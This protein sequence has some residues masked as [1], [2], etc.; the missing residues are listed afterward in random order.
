MN[1]VRESSAGQ[2]HWLLRSMLAPCLIGA[3]LL[4]FCSPS[5]TAG[6]DEHP[7]AMEE[8]VPVL[9]YYYIWFTPT[10]WNRAKTDFPL[11]GRYSSDE[12]EVMRQHVQ[13]AKSAGIDGFIVSWKN[14]ATLNQRLEK[15]I[16]V[17]SEEDFKLA[18]I[19]EGLDFEREPLT[20][21][22]VAGDIDLFRQ[23][24]AAEAVFDVYAKPVVI[25]SGTWR[26]T[27]EEVATVTEGRREDIFI[28]ASEKNVDGYSRLADL[29]DGDAYYWS[30]VN[31]DTFPGYQEKLD[32][33]SQSVHSRG[34]LWIAPA[35]PGF[36]ARLVGGTR[37]VERSGGDMLRRQMNAATLSS[38]DAIG[39]IS[40]NEFS[41]N[42]HIE[43]SENYGTHSLTVLADILGSEAPV[44]INF[45]SDSPAATDVSYGLPLL[46]GMAVLIVA[47]IGM[48]GWHRSRMDKTEQM[49]RR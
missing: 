24:Y 35:A 30:S 45:D 13:W 47:S 48:I 37:V 29:V 6:Q 28:L 21:E 12:R 20:V 39:L 34:G 36:D 23:R 33:M 5:A 42:S 41:E 49:A 22:R 7:P 15:M 40:W 18:I 1:T 32:A 31:P 10:S 43:P 27:R 38:P 14:T 8:P 9:A 11:I 46:L 17:A 4:T 2:P 26:Y 3:V 44:V 16:D 19:Y 25:W